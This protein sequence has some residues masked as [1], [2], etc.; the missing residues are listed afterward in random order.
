MA[1]AEHLFC[2]PTAQ[3]SRGSRSKLAARRFLTIRNR[4]R[5]T[6]VLQRTNLLSRKFAEP[7]TCCSVVCAVDLP[8]NKHGGVP[9]LWCLRKM[10]S[11]T[12]A[13]SK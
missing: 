11:I 3:R 10:E 2:S 9:A 5:P 13:V 8:H 4:C 1:A 12:A 6:A 7:D